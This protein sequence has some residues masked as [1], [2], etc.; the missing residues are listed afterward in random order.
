MS[1][2][3]VRSDEIASGALQPMR[4]EPGADPD[5]PVRYTLPFADAS[6][7]MNDLL[8]KQLEIRFLDQI[9]CRA[10]SRASRK[11][12]GGGYCYDCF[13]TLA[14]CDL[15]MVSPDRCHF[16]AGTCREPQWAESFCMRPH[17]VYLA[18][19][20]GLKVGITRASNLPGRWLDQGATQ[21]TEIL[22]TSTREQAGWAERALARYVSD[23]TD[24]RALVSRKPQV[25]DLASEAER[26]KRQAAIPI[27]QVFDRFP[28]GLAWV[29]DLQIVRFR[30]PVDR[31]ATPTRLTLSAGASIG[32][33]LLG[34]RGQYLLFDSGVFNVARHC[35]Y[36][37]RL[38]YGA[39]ALDEGPGADQMSLFE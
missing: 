18:N 20:A 9:S 35:S 24:W 5:R 19:S 26:L 37:V 6:G 29:S 39:P 38:G 17:V 7:T 27:Q 28:G 21:A 10:C 32:G 25:L 2:Q 34:I 16:A 1:D 22:R 31:L 30:Y 13:K 33:Y 11:S 14:R 23:R 15:C 3:R 12:Y 36:H 4:V 8:G